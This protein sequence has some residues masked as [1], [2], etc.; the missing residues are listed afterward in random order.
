[1]TSLVKRD[2]S[3]MWRSIGGI[4]VP[5]VV[6]ESA[7]FLVQLG[8]VA[9]MGRI[10][11]DVLYL[12]SLYQPIG[13]LLVALSVAFAVS[14]QVTAAVSKGA[15]RPGDVLA[16]AGSLARVW[17]LGFVAVTVILGVA[18]PWIAAA[19][20]TQTRLIG[21][22]AWFL[23]WTG[24]AALV[25]I[26]PALLASCLRGYGYVA[27]ATT[28]V[29]GTAAV[30]IGCVA[31]LGLGTRIGVFA[32][33][34]GDAVAG[35]AGLAVG[36]V[37]M[38]RTELWHPVGLRTWRPEVLGRLRTVGAPVAATFLIISAYNFA[39][40]DLLGRFGEWAVAG[41]SVASA[42][43]NLVLL[44]GTMLGTA[45]AIVVNQ[46]RGAGEYRRVGTALRGGLT[47]ATAVYAVIAVLVWAL[48]QPVATVLTG[49]PRVA[50]EAAGYLGAIGLTFFVQGPVLA[51]LTVMEHTGG[52]YTAVGL[53]TIYFALIV[54][55]GVLVVGSSHG[56]AGFYHV[57]GIC[58]LIGVSVPFAALRHLRRLSS[59]T[60]AA[61]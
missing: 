56:S 54:V 60:N 14:N 40:L 18:A 11:D 26:G 32:V 21:S 59:G 31:G 39:V 17:L 42:L 12:R 2:S 44:P 61:F 55:A 23:R 20:G 41:F 3:G 38:R 58:N 22:Y 19:I 10:G 6:A 50:S 5:L 1:M 49:D 8:I 46:R 45:T 28:I 24:A 47:L 53:N 13:L 37:L 34:I 35:L 33:P 51:V 52:G 16:S 9:I 43:Q 4:A 48:A 29:L 36:V 27:R 57:I 7:D 25:E 15:G 30:R